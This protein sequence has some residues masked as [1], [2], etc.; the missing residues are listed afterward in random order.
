MRR[1]IHSKAHLPLACLLLLLGACAGTRTAA[2]PEGFYGPMALAVPFWDA[3]PRPVGVLLLP[4]PAGDVYRLDESG[5]IRSSSWPYAYDGPLIQFLRETRVDFEWLAS[6]LTALLQERGFAPRRLDGAG[7]DRETMAAEPTSDA[8]TRKY[9]EIAKAAGDAE[10][11]LAITPLN[12][13][14]NQAYSGPL[15]SGRR[16]A[17][18]EIEAMLV[19]VT[20]RA[21]L[22]QGFASESALVPLAWSARKLGHEVPDEPKLEA[23]LKEALASAGDALV[24]G[25]AAWDG[26]EASLVWV[27]ER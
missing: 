14:F 12:W 8:M 1:S 19:D 22:W 23:T 16:Y 15:P 7:I 10:L 2:A 11:V 20:N 17:F 9:D 18:F 3:P 6:D 13:G 25:L 5:A 26:A 24:A 4:P 27:G 21:I